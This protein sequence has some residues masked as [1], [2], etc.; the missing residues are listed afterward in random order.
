M[1]IDA[2]QIRLQVLMLEAQL[3]G[4]ES[5]IKELKSIRCPVCEGTGSLQIESLEGTAVHY[6]YPT[7]QDC[8]GTGHACGE[9]D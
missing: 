6:E 9:I 2:D 8:S 3:K 5:H 1:A 4:I 7:C